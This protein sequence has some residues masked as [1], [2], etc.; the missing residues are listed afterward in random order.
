VTA[1]PLDFAWGVFYTSAVRSLTR[2]WQAL[3]R[4]AKVALV[5][6]AILGAGAVAVRTWLMVSYH[7]AFLG[8]PDSSQYAL[9]ATRNIFRDAQRPAG[10]PFFLRLVHHLS[11]RLSFT[12]AVQHALGIATGVLLYKAVRRTG[13]PAW[14]GLLPAAIVFFGGTGLIL[15]HTLLADPLLTFLQAAGVYAAIRALYTQQ[16][17]WPLVAGVLIGLSFWVKTVAIASAIVVPV[18]LLCAVPGGTRRRLLSAATALAAVIVMIGAYVGTQYYF[19]GYL[20]YERQSAWNLYGRVATFVNCSSFRPPSGTR[21]LC[22]TQP[23][24]QRLPQSYYVFGAGAPAVDRFGTP[25]EAP[26]SANAQIQAFSVA[27]I[28]AQPIAYAKAIVRGLGRYV[29]PQVGEGSLPQ[30]LREA[31]TSPT[32]TRSFLR[33][34]SVLYDEDLGYIGSAAALRPLATYESYTR[35][36]GPL[37]VL[38]LVAAI[39]GMF[40][41]SVRIRWAAA[42]FTLTALASITVAVATDGYD[43]RFAY[44][45][46]G[47]LAA[48]A[49]LGAWGIGSLLARTIRRRRRGRGSRRLVLMQRH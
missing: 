15:E 43:A 27:A 13:A 31:V 34:F 41:L 21:F 30:E 17:R 11:H 2:R 18:V 28:E 7:P 19:T 1:V 6:I 8:Y 20:G 48:G 4:D 5:G 36:Q 29:F 42:L 3:E 46:F 40:T 47:P 45:T 14:L 26:A 35:V 37:L 38:L 10:Y 22:P 49:T 16:L 32:G 39:L 44:P 24:G 33:N 9:A 23:L 12:I 25:W